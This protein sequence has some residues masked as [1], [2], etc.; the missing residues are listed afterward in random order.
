MV[1]AML[2]PGEQPCGCPVCGLVAVLVEHRDQY[3]VPGSER[4]RALSLAVVLGRWAC[5]AY[6]P[7]AQRAG[8]DAQDAAT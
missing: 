2:D 6:V 3:A 5:P 7:V 4:W 1:P 8:L